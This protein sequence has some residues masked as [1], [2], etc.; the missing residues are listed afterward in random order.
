MLISGV[1]EKGQKK[2]NSACIAIIG[3]GAIGSLS[4]DYLVRAG[5]GKIILVDKDKIEEMNI[6]R[7]TLYSVKDIGKRKVDVARR[8]LL[9]A[10][11]DVEIIV[12]KEYISNEN[13][14]EILKSASLILDCTDNMASR[15][16]IDDYCQKSKKIWI[17]AAASG[18]KCNVL[19]LDE[20]SDFSRYFGTGSFGNCSE[21]AILGPVAGLASCIQSAEAIK[22][23]VGLP[24]FEHLQR[25]DLLN[26]KH[27][28]IKVKKVKK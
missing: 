23:I 4:A 25:F 7:Q 22:V 24:Y 12:I 20:P 11:P 17:H 6:H 13:A 10:N 28:I 18:T 21:N 5:V 2:L 19:V 8:E 26:N 9:R 1:G 15:K 27:E 16:I 14:H 3:V